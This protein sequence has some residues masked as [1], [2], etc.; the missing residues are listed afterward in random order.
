MNQFPQQN[1][2]SARGNAKKVIFVKKTPCGS[3]VQ[4]VDTP[5][6]AAQ[7]CSNG[8]PDGP[9]GQESGTK[10]ETYAGSCARKIKALRFVF[11][12]TLFEID[13]NLKRYVG[14][15]AISMDRP[16]RYRLLSLRT[17]IVG[18]LHCL[19]GFRFLMKPE[20]QQTE[21]WTV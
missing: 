18:Q 13:S 10:T 4:T 1:K 14:G 19:D 12:S 15:L 3:R 11:V 20:A 21:N 8:T 6:P 2:G 17:M 16:L 7:R 5:S 9:H